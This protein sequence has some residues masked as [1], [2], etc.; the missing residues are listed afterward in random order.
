MDLILKVDQARRHSDQP[1]LVTDQEL[2]AWAEGQRPAAVGALFGFSGLPVGHET[3]GKTAMSWLCR[4]CMHS[5]CR[6]SGSRPRET[7][8]AVSHC[9][10][11]LEHPDPFG[12]QLQ[13]LASS[14]LADHDWLF[15]DSVCL[16]H[17]GRDALKERN[18]QKAL[19]NMHMLYM[20]DF[21]TT[22]CIEG[23]ATASE[24][25]ESQRLIAIYQNNGCLEEVQLSRLRL[26]ENATPFFD[27]GW[28]CSE[29]HWSH[30]K[31]WPKV[32]W[33]D[34]VGEDK[35]SQA[36]APMP[37]DVFR[38]WLEA[39]KLH[40]SR[41]GDAGVV[42]R[43]Q[44]KAFKTKAAGCAFLHLDS[45]AAAQLPKLISALPYLKH[46]QR[47][48]LRAVGIGDFEAQLLATGLTANVSI[49]TLFL[50]GNQLQ[51]PGSA[52]LA[53]AVRE[54]KALAVLSLRCNAISDEGASAFAEALTVNGNLREICFNANQIRD[55]AGLSLAV[56][57]LFEIWRRDA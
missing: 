51:D 15:I 20:H 56:F 47:L 42:S 2:L 55:V 31:N 7:I 3:L 23:H 21:T 44:E 19:Q 12:H 57:L 5:S 9:W 1:A 30:L 43:L 33:L 46:M 40:F 11:S 52:V 18:F 14:F 39:S 32:V 8:F 45:M 24:R 13:I 27:R 49:Q 48:S 25:A 53:E 38:E 34:H 22:L 54:N 41:A 16:Y 26:S 28:C 10:E 50:D 35:P 29:V 17:Q 6:S 37:P 4:G 36:Q